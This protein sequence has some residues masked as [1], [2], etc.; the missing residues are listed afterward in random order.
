MDGECVCDE[1]ND[2]LL[3]KDEDEK[4]WIWERLRAE[5]W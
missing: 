3:K 2:I 5:D 1:E 4:G